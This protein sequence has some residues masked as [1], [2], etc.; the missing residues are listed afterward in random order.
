[1]D[2]HRPE[3]LTPERTR[4]HTAHGAPAG[5]RHLAAEAPDVA[6][7]PLVPVTIWRLPPRRYPKGQPQALFAGLTPRLAAALVTA[8]THPGQVVLDWSED[9]ALA[10]ACGAGGRRYQVI[11]PGQ[12][13]EA[14]ALVVLRAGSEP[15]GDGQLSSSP[16]LLRSDGH[17][18]VVVTPTIAVE[19]NVTAALLAAAHMAGL[20]YLEHVIAVVA[21]D[22]RRRPAHAARQVAAVP[23]EQGYID[24]LVFVLRKDPDATP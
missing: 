11:D 19:K 18:A 1:M 5:P 14:A 10:G 20:S 17:L 23:A 13:A 12:T 6:D 21:P 3:P 7:R 8:Y 4:P 15:S 22:S 16:A 2:D 9:L 24:L